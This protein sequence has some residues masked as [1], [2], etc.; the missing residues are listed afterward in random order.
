[1]PKAEP[2]PHRRVA[3]VGA[4]LSIDAA[5]R[6]LSGGQS[7]ERRLE[8]IRVFYYHGVVE[9]K[10]DALLERNFVL[11]DEFRSHLRFLRRFRVLS[12]GE[13]AEELSNARGKVKRGAVITFDD[14]YAN[15]LMVA[16]IFQAARLPWSLFI[17][18]GGIGSGS[19][20]WPEELALLLLHGRIAQLGALGQTWRTESGDDR[21]VAFRSTQRAMKAMPSEVRRRTLDSI[22]T[23]FP[24]DETRRLLF[25]FPSM[26]MLSWDQTRQLATAGVDVGS[27]G[28]D[29][30]IHHA[31]QEAATR[32][33]ELT[34][35]K[36][37]LTKRLNRECDFFAF[38]NGDFISPSA[39]EVRQAGYKLGFTTH[40]STVIRGANPFVLPRLY[41][42][43]PSQQFE[44]EFF[45]G[46]PWN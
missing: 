10:K 41:P 39:D 21:V 26:Q 27:H 34:A 35:S 1:L 16:E 3:V 44:R 18:T 11:L 12:L 31:A 45:W 9:Q 23:Q 46:S 7:G 25:E 38:P 24:K 42:A 30:E 19:T 4:P 22:R 13:L 20:L 17:S 28:V 33:H 36:S 40:P 32:C 43:G 15:N 29:H 5:G 37:E 14:G 8:G 6:Y 2:A